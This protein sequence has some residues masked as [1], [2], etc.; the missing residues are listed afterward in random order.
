MIEKIEVGKKY[1]LDGVAG[2]VKED[3]GGD[4]YLVY[5][6]VKKD[7]GYHQVMTKSEFLDSLTDIGPKPKSIEEEIKE[8]YPDYIVRTFKWINNVW[9][10][11]I[12]NVL[13]SP[14][15]SVFTKGFYRFVYESENFPP[16]ILLDS[17]FLGGHK[18]PPKLPVAALFKKEK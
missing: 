17:P 2:T 8:K 5:L 3:L 18:E 13:R 10:L 4:E 15:E 14:S 16:F 12:D 9:L 6:Q 11:S 1:I 7:S